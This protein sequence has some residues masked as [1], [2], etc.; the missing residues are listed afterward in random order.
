MSFDDPWRQGRPLVRAA[1]YAAALLMINVTHGE[2]ASFPSVAPLMLYDAATKTVHSYI[3]SGKA[4][5]AATLELFKSRG[6]KTV[7]DLSILS[8]L[9]PASPDVIVSLLS[10]YGTMSF[11]EIAAPAIAMAMARE[12]FPAHEIMYK[13][14]HFSL[15][16]LIGFQV[17]F[18]YDTKVWLG[19]QFW[20]PMHY[21]D[22]MRFPDLAKT[23]KPSPAPKARQFARVVTAGPVSQPSA[24][25]STKAPSRRRSSRCTGNRAAFSPRPI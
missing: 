2:A 25:I 15:I 19:E 23:P 14:M 20:L 3:G 17:L 7:S 4:S 9:V 24:T 12:G 18:P 8:Q 21:K 6:C 10:D 22:R 1:N 16:N 13:N 5:A 11:G